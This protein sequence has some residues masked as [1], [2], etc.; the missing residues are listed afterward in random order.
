MAASACG[1]FLFLGPDRARKHQRLA[2]LRQSLTVHALDSHE[3]NARQLAPADLGTLI[4]EYPTASPARLIVVEEAHRLSPA[5][6]KVLEAH[7]EVLKHVA[8][9]VLLSE[10]PLEASHPLL[11]LKPYATVES[12]E[13]PGRSKSS[14]AF[15]LLEAVARR[16]AAVA[17]RLMQDQL[18]EG[19]EVVELFGLIGW[20]LQRWLTVSHLA[21][22]GMAP[23]RIAAVTGWS[24]W[25]VDRIRTE[26]AGRRT[27]GLARLAKR[28]WEADVEVKTGQTIPRMAL[29]RLIVELC[30]PRP[31]GRGLPS[32]SRSSPAV[33]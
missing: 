33:A 24:P 12:F 16:D 4:R 1:L 22:A 9:V 7:H 30:L 13:E 25:Q 17:L 23:P 26:L 2:Q 19:K 29:E 31:E 27:E 11:S 21:D 15:A 10:A 5:C 20:Q 3:L 32:P 28:C 14:G 18:A 6:L 8:C